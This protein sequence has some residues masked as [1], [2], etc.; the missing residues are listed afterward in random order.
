MLTAR[1]TDDHHIEGLE[2][3][4]DDYITKPF[5]IVLLG[6]RIKNIIESRDML[7]KKF[8]RELELQP[9]GKIIPVKEEDFI[10]KIIDIIESNL[11]NNAFDVEHLSREVG[12]SSRHLL[13]KMQNLTDYTPVE[14][15]RTYRLKRAEQLLLQKN[16]T[17]SEVAYD[18]G[19][20]DPNY[21]SKCFQK[22]YGKTPKDFVA[23]IKTAF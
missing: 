8:R 13:N 4:A 10:K 19:F 12:L 18:V 17:I 20:S 1:A 11:S 2:A 15:I 3:G 23:A 6:A 16:L 7:R 5:N 22:Q 14:F 21:F 9:L